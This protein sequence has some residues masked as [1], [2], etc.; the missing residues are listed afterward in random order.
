[1][2]GTSYADFYQYNR[3]CFSHGLTFRVAWSSSNSA[4]GVVRGAPFC[5]EFCPV[6]NSFISTGQPQAFAMGVHTLSGSQ[7]RSNFASYD[8]SMR[9]VRDRPAHVEQRG[10][11][12]RRSAIAPYETVDP[13]HTALTITEGAEGLL[14]LAS[15]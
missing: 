1:M 5:C 9:G 8:A 11:S 12:Y 6:K 15:L 2:T 10:L 4:T 14:R 7:Q 3:T 13:Y